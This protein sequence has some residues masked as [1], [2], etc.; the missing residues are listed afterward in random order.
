MAYIRGG[1]GAY[2]RDVY[3]ELGYVFGGRIFAGG[4]LYKGGVLTGFYGIHFL[5]KAS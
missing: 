1:G 2:I 5:D 4:G 3:W